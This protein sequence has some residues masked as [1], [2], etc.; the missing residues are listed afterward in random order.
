MLATD[1][2]QMLCLGSDGKVAW[3]QPL[4]FGTP[5]GTPLE[6]AE[7]Y[8]LASAAGVVWSAG[9]ADGEPLLRD[10]Q[11][12]KIDLGRP[13]GTGPVLLG[14]KLLVVQRDGSLHLIEQP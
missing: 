12:R 2:G 10:G 5:V 3:Q 11:P 8:V 1:D 14:N 13:L 7:G 4:P 6:T 9:K